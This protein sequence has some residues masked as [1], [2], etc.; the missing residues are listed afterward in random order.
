MSVTVQDT[1]NVVVPV[2]HFPPT[3]AKKLDHLLERCYSI[4]QESNRDKSSD[5]P[6]AVILQAMYDGEMFVQD[7]LFMSQLENLA[8]THYV[9][10]HVIGKSN[11]KMGITLNAIKETLG[12]RDIKTLVVRAHGDSDGIQL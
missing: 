5:A 9:V 2:S 7:T 8:K 1:Y 3:N 10:L 11:D 12:N 4:I 6:A